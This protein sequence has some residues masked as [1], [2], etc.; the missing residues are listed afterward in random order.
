MRKYGVKD[1]SKVGVFNPRG[2]VFLSPGSNKL[3][4]QLLI[5]VE[6]GNKFKR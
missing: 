3:I 2:S 5:I 6:D 4:A 1:G